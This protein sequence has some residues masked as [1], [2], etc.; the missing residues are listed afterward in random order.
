MVI[1]LSNQIGTTAANII[2]SIVFFIIT[3]AAIAMIILF[4]TRL[5][6]KRLSIDRN[7][8]PPRLTLCETIAIDRTRHLVLV[9]CDNKE[10]LLLIGGLTDIV[11]EANINSTSLI[12]KKDTQPT[13]S[14]TE[15]ALSNSPTDRRSREHTHSNN[16]TS[17][18]KQHVEDSAITAEIEGRQE[19]SLFIPSQNK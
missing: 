7:K 14:T 17:F 8:R 9:R 10:H 15:T 11:V 5:K 2:T 3:C 12:K 4:V 19:P 16:T 13:L 1:W 18:M 6:R